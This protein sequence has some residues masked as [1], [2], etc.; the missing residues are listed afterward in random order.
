M[1]VL[2]LN[3]SYAHINT[4]CGVLE[5]SIAYVVIDGIVIDFLKGRE[6]FHL[7]GENSQR[8]ED[9]HLTWDVSKLKTSGCILYIKGLRGG[10]SRRLKS[11]MLENIPCCKD[12][13]WGT[14]V[15]LKSENLY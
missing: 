9:S 7:E 2:A 14:C 8:D 1:L 4:K 11:R 13:K 10:V 12:L 15:Q 3:R 5:R 6:V